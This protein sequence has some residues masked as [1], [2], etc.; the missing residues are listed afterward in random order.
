MCEWGV[1]LFPLW[2]S[3]DW[4][5]SFWGT[6]CTTAVVQLFCLRPQIHSFEIPPQSTVRVVAELLLLS[7]SQNKPFRSLLSTL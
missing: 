6:S 7:V 1:F 3:E 4:L 2:Y 5:F